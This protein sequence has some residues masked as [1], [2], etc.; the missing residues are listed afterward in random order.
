MLRNREGYADPT[1]G[2][3]VGLVMKEYKAK[4]REEWR[5]QYEMKNQ[6][7]VYVISRYAGNIEKNVD[8]AI[9]ACKYLIGKNKQPIASHLL[10]PQILGVGDKDMES[11][12]LGLMYGLSLLAMCDE[13]YCFETK[14]GLSAGMEQEIREAK[15]LGKPIHYVRLEEI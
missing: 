10:Y 13:V 15:R 5:K 8:D 2:I 3:A 14:S 4:Q 1:A 12:T 7:K 9:K 6:S 11:R